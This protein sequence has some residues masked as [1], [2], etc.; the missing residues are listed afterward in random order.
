MQHRR[1]VNQDTPAE[2]APQASSAPAPVIPFPTTPWEPST[3]EP[4]VPSG[5]SLVDWNTETPNGWGKGHD[6]P[7]V[8]N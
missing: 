5:L 8:W 7:G 1:S 3:S 2:P 6:E 4:Q